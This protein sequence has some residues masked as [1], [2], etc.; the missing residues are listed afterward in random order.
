MS[1]DGTDTSSGPECLARAGAQAGEQ[2][3][4][5]GLEAQTRREGSQLQPLAPQAATWR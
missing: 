3:E 4:R 1:C 5:E 2:K